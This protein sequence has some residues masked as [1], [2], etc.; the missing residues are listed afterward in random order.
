MRRTS[1]FGEG[2]PPPAAAEP[3]AATTRFTQYSSSRRTNLQP[4][5]AAAIEHLLD[6]GQ[7]TLQ[8]GPH[9]NSEEGLDFLEANYSANRSQHRSP[10][11]SS[12]PQE[13]RGRPRCQFGPPCRAC[14]ASSRGCS[15]TAVK[16]HPGK[17]RIIGVNLVGAV[18][19]RHTRGKYTHGIPPTAHFTSQDRQ[20]PPT[21]GYTSAVPAQSPPPPC[22]LR[23]HRASP[24]AR[25]ST[26]CASGRRQ[27]ELQ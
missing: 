20:A 2:F 10:C 17:A 7:R 18:C 1:S 8:G 15:I 21:I 14:W 3:E 13:T 25:A 11:W 22:M 9:D 24:A 23:L 12:R 26:T 6:E 4:S 19:Q 27:D 16:I 5:T